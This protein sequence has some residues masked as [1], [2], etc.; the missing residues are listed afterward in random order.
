ML[1]D[2]AVRAASGKDKAYKL[3]DGGG[4]YLYVTPK[5]HKSWRYKYRHDGKEY[6]LTLGSYPEVSLA[7]AREK[8]NEAKRVK[9][10]GRDPR[11]AA[12]RTKLLGANNDMP[13]LEVAAREWHDLNTGRWKPV[14]ANDV[15]TSLERD[16]FPDLGD[17]PLDEIDK[18]L[19]LATL[20]K[21][22][23]RGAIETAR[24][25]KQR[26]AAIY[27][28]SIAKGANVSNPA[29][30]LNDALKP[31]P[32]SKQYPALINV[33]S[34]RQLLA[35]IDRAGASPVTRLAARFLAL[36]AQRPGMVRHMEWSELQDIDWGN[37]KSDVSDARWIVP[38]GKIKQELR[39]RSDEAFEHIV[40]LAPQAV[41]TLRA[42]RLLTGRSQLVFPGSRSG[43]KPMS[44]NAVG[45]LYNREGYKGKHVPHG[46]RSS[47]STIMN[48]MAER[49]LGVDLR[50]LADR[51][52]IDLMLAHTPK[53]M[54][55]SEM[56]YNRA[57]YMDRRRELAIEW[58]DLIMEGAL[59]TGEIIDSPR[60]KRR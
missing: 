45:Y 27:R 23:Q 46:W 58:A 32:P 49:K 48:E 56:R 60:R 8:R 54:S 6:L 47:F 52:V 15:I 53:G 51:M 39:L 40:P 33:P 42:V 9:R 59:P 12:K 28:Y 3:T 35:D 26:V 19:L 36:T 17:L 5:N 37:P 55:A 14:H 44:E 43:T 1:T 22:E 30:D 10:E 41:E 2:K 7:D 31:L 24:R 57:R 29:A 25:V 16:I 34:I 38:A 21:I 13:S 4:L 50:L 20:R 18:P 11:H